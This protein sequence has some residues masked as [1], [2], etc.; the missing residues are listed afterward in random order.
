MSASL[1][2]HFK[3]A[4]GA[5]ILPNA[6][7]REK[8]GKPCSD[9]QVC[10]CTC[11][12]EAA[13]I[14]DLGA[15]SFC[16]I[17]TVIWRCKGKRFAGA[18]PTSNMQTHS[19]AA[20]AGMDT[21]DP[22]GNASRPS[23]GAAAG[24]AL[25]PSGATGPNASSSK[26][27]S[28]SGVGKTRDPEDGASPDGPGESAFLAPTRANAGE[29]RGSS[30]RLV[31]AP[32][33]TRR[34]AG[35]PEEGSGGK[36][37]PPR[38]GKGA[39]GQCMAARRIAAAATA[40]AAQWAREGGSGENG[41]GGAGGVGALYASGGVP[42]LRISQAAQAMVAQDGTWGVGRHKKLDNSELDKE[43]RGSVLAPQQP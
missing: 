11:I 7:R 41:G 14:A 9:V 36:K 40:A 16:S 31:D 10:L 15:W 23:S 21:V 1:K 4:L 33:T 6:A 42:P 12:L 2:R 3:R 20:G 13:V 29:S 38:K 27:G 32:G 19:P 5:S 8:E 35:K 37:L 24:S 26:G 39:G 22:S 28:S 18:L 43:H 17:P 34:A 25:L 30:G